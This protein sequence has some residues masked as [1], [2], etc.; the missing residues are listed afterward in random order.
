MF[1]YA[2]T[3]RP[4]L[5]C[6]HARSAERQ[7]T[8]VRTDL[9]FVYGFLARPGSATQLRKPASFRFGIIPI[10]FV[11]LNDEFD[12]QKVPIVVVQ[13]KNSII[14]LKIKTPKF[15]YSSKTHRQSCRHDRARGVDGLKEA[16][17]SLVPLRKIADV[18]HHRPLDWQGTTPK[19]A[20]NELLN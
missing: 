17:R 20:E 10:C 19:N 5:T 14:D 13:S 18:I 7:F 9:Q 4:S 6:S 15:F 11:D 2:C 3:G 16:R 1:T 8:L 12:P